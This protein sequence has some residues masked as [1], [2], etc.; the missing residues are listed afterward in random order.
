MSTWPRMTIEE[1]TETLIDYRGKTPIK[2]SSGV[3]LIT[4]K[5]IKDGFINDVNFEYI[6]AD[7]YDAR[8]T[9]GLPKQW[10]ILITTEAPCG[11]VA[12]LRTAERVALAQRVIL[13]R[14]K[15]EV[16]DQSFYFHALKSPMVQAQLRARSTGT[17]VLGVKQSELRQVE[18]PVPP[19]PTQQKIASILSAYDDLIDNNTRRIKLL[20]EIAR[21]LYREWFVH[22]RFPGHHSV[23]L[24]DS[25]LGPIP[26]GWET[27]TLREVTTYINR[28]VSPK[29]N[30]TSSSL[31]INQKC[32]RDGRLTLEP[33]RKHSTN[34]PAEK[35]V[36]FGDALINSTGIGTLGRV[37]QVYE[38]IPNCTVDS[39]VT[40]VR[41][42]DN[43]DLDYFGF[44]IL[45]LQAH[46]DSQGVGSTGQTELSRESIARS[47]I[48][49]PPKSLQYTFGTVVRPMRTSV[50]SL[51]A[52][53][54]NLRRTRDLLLPKLIS[55]EVA[56]YASF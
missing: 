3:R 18:V 1:V 31:V 25:P 39:H 9:R 47:S 6:A 19:L 21:S 15:P 34:I 41:P 35:A 54:R 38:D 23:P 50:V 7:S 49:L 43:V 10:D 46:F 2:S 52:R 30:D 29:Y 11:E 44:S 28:G 13:L 12:Q 36:Q 16:I 40:I 37:A 17:T 26:D 20:E 53:N 51:I 4:A 56:S 22:F 55:G 5:V 24:G 8:M 48:L 42:A 14:G 32:I 27:A 45:A 33:A